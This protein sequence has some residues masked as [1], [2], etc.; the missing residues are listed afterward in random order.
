MVSF[1]FIPLVI[2][3]ILLSILIGLV[4][5]DCFESRIVCCLVGCIALALI[6][7]FIF[8]FHSEVS[9]K[10]EQKE[11]ILQSAPSE[12]QV[13]INDSTYVYTLN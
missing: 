4:V 13:I 10:K 1:L 12:M 5:Y 8:C 2:Q 11:I 9:R 6:M 7:Y 3:G